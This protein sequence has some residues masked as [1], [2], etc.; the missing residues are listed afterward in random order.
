MALFPV[1]IVLGRT[2]WCL[3]RLAVIYL[4]FKDYSGIVGHLYFIL[5]SK[6]D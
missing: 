1:L 5:V 3:V 4:G 2:E 6:G